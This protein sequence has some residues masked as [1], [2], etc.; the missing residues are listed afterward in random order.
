MKTKGLSVIRNVLLTL[1][2][3]LITFL[4][5]TGFLAI[6]GGIFV[7]WMTIGVFSH[8]S[9]DT[10]KWNIPLTQELDSTCYR[11][12]MAKDIRDNLLKQGES[13]QFVENL[14]GKPDHIQE[15]EYSYVLGMCSGFGF[16]YDNLHIYFNKQDKIIYSKIRQH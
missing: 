13:K 15:N 1:K 8:Q 11:G 6:L 3:I 2:K 16:D 12:G 7:W 10:K 9:F 14:L 4:A 5:I